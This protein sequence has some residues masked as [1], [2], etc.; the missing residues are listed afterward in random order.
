M[1]KILFI[2]LSLAFSHSVFAKDVHKCIVN[3]SVTYQSRPCAGAIT[4]NQKQQMQQKLVQRTASQNAKTRELQKLNQA[5]A[6]PVH[7]YSQSQHL[8]RRSDNGT[9]NQI[10]DSVEGKKKS[11]A[12]A[13]DAYQKTKNR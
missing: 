5:Q 9:S 13:Q 1:K 12:L 3:G 7:Q 10:P 8:Q 4:P 6:Q 11:L 2:G